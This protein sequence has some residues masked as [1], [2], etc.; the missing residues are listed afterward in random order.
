[1]T[2]IKPAENQNAQPEHQPFPRSW[3]LDGVQGL[4]ASPAAWAETRPHLFST[5]RLWVDAVDLAT[6]AEA[7]EAIESVLANSAYQ[8]AYA[9]RFEIPLDSS[10]NEMPIQTPGVLFGYDFHL[11][12]NGPK[13][14]EIN[15][16]A[17]GAF[18]NSCLGDAW[19]ALLADRGCAPTRQ[20]LL[21]MF[22]QDWQAC[23]QKKVGGSN[24]I[25]PP[26]G[27][28]VIVDEAPTEQYLYPEF[29]LCAQWL[30]E[31]GWQTAIADPADLNW[32]GQRLSLNGQLVS[33]I[34]NRLTD[35]Y[36]HA[37]SMA[38][39]RAAYQAGAVLLSPQPRC[40]A[41]MA[42]KRH[43]VTLADATLL[44]DLG[45]S[46]QQR[47]A[48]AK[49]IPPC[50][51]VSASDAESL[52]KSRKQLFF[53]P[54][55]GFGSRATYRGDKLTRRVFDEILQADYIAQTIVPPSERV[56]RVNDALQT[57]KVDVRNYTYCGQVLG[58]VG[59]LYQGQTTNFRTPGGGF[60]P[61][62]CADAAAMPE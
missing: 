46:S 27:L 31:H 25:T 2:N 41:Q 7:I 28:L 5:T 1:M 17:G 24:P 45:V 48:I 11:S 12:A 19:A 62:Y 13:L 14:I 42:D 37:E 40:H 35:F 55:A 8:A 16:N 61:V 21:A 18:L 33:M 60:A 23:L 10:K 51:A 39:L 52:W 50:I 49:V 58:V 9:A 15:T 34:Y 30:A 59:R 4:D 22:E 53:K 32:D 47:Q 57:L 3:F 26:P 29:V 38:A 44:E 43:L 20:A 6:M 54:V 56:V 36:L